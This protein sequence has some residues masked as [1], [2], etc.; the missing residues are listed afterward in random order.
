MAN[1]ISAT[2]RIRIDLLK[3]IRV[4]ARAARNTA[5]QQVVHQTLA[6]ILANELGMRRGTATRHSPLATRGLRQLA[7]WCRGNPLTTA[8]LDNNH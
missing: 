5:W 6:A 3:Q 2:R 7:H 4:P 8:G 1:C